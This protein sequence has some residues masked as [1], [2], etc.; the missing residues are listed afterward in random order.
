M[1]G[2]KPISSYYAKLGKRESANED[3]SPTLR[4]RQKKSVGSSN[5]KESDSKNS[6]ALVNRN[7]SENLVKSQQPQ[8][9]RQEFNISSKPNEHEALKTQLSDL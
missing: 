1:T 9:L 7:S 8:K 4:K 2:V 5:S 3:R 6:F